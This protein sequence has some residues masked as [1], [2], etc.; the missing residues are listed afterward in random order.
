MGM[1]S[2]CLR[3]N[4]VYICKL[5]LLSTLA[6][7]ASFLQCG[8]EC[9]DSPWVRVLKISGSECS[10]LN[11]TSVST[12]PPRP[13]RAQGTLWKRKKEECKSWRLGEGHEMLFSGQDMVLELMNSQ[14]LLRSA[15]IKTVNV[16]PWTG[17]ALL[18]P[19]A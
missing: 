17:G 10:T 11:G 7:E 1:F 16:S 4:S 12:S 19:Y 8:V 18:E 5:K 14:Q 6:S 9:R 3:K 15:Q 13:R 2:N